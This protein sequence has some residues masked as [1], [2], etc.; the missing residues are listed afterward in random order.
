MAEQIRVKCRERS[1]IQLTD[2]EKKM[3]KYQTGIDEGSNWSTS[4]LETLART[5]KKAYVW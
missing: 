3:R 1:T 4:P 5:V 2:S